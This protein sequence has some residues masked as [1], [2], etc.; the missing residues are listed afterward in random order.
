GFPLNDYFPNFKAVTY[1]GPGGTGSTVPTRSFYDSFDDKDLRKKDQEGWFYTTYYTNGTGAKFDLGAPY[2]FKHF[3]QT[4]LGGPGITPTRNNN[5]NVNLIRYAEVLLIYAE[6]QN[7][8]G[9]P[10]QEAYNALKRIRDRAQLETPALG[11]FTTDTFRQAVWKERW[12]DRK[13][14]V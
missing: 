3:N 13:S 8:V 9:G 4:A 7:E 1:S 11:Q 10:N 12:Q 6:A 2:V 5:L 14:V